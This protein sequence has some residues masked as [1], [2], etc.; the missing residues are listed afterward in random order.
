MQGAVSTCWP[1]PT[2]R[3]SML[4]LPLL[5][6]ILLGCNTSDTT[7]TGTTN[8]PPPVN[9]SGHDWPQFN[10]DVARSGSSPNETGLSATTIPTMKRQQVQIDGTVDAAAIY[11]HNV[12]V[13]GAAH[14]VF[15]ATTTYGKTLAI[16]ANDGTILWR[17]TPASFSQLSGS[18]RITNVVPDADPD[19]SAIYTASPDG[20]VAKLAVAD[21]HVVWS[22]AITSLAQREKI[23]SALNLSSGHVIATT[24]GYVGD[25]PNYQGHVTLLNSSTG[26]MLSTWNS[27]CS[28]RTG[29]IDPN[30]CAQSGSAIWGRSGAVVD[31]SGNILVATGN[32]LWDG[33]TN[34]GD[35]IIQLD[36]LASRI[37][38][39][40][41]PTN[42]STLESTDADLGSVSP[43][44]VDATHVIQGG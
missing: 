43:A 14:D 44:I 23:T 40:Y 39:N 19:R 26:Q 28:N 22:T 24:G 4:R 31:A 35:A 34:W 33:A 42:T 9:S 32:G 2:G 17:Y 5:G 21:G 13:N 7:H 10:F 12:P 29:I 25:A 37:L 30:S 41:T 38:A 1:L 6:L 16:D 36:P 27:L 8:P 11:L 18:S 20:N 3:L 15:F